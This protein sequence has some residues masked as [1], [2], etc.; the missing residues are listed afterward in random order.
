MA[1]DSYAWY[2]SAIAGA[3]PPIS[4]AQPNCGFFRRRASKDGPWLPA[5]IWIDKGKMICRV[6]GDAERDPEKEWTWLAKHPMPQHDVME[7]FKTGK[8]PS[9]VLIEPSMGH[10]NPPESLPELV[11]EEVERAVEWIRKNP[12]IDSK[13]N[14][15]IAANMAALLVKRANESDVRREEEKRP[16]IE[17]GRE[18]QAKWAAVIDPARATAKALKDI[19]GRYMAAEETRL[20]KI[21]QDRQAAE[22]AKQEAERAKAAAL[23]Q[24]PPEPVVV[25]VKPVKV[26]AGGA[27]GAKMGLKDVWIAEVTDHAL[28][29]EFFKE[30]RSVREVVF[31]LATEK[32]KSE[33]EA[34]VIPGVKVTRLRKA[35]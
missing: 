31:I 3:A 6:G 14:C 17:A 4:D 33:K 35:Q 11:K 26:N 2:R 5:A 8:W 24:P 20:L 13:I 34:C 25:P 16:H 23:N 12:I 29:L 21:E 7:A 27:R 15:D 28:A 1:T 30:D 9:E 19:A 18:V 10:N 22:R 32:A